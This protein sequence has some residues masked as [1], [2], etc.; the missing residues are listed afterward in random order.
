ML[1]TNFADNNAKNINISHI[2]FTI[3]CSYNLFVLFKEIVNFYSRSKLINQLASKL[4][5]LEKFIQKIFSIHN[6]FKISECQKHK[7]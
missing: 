6:N 2:L 1:I 7:A 4:N 3:H 5:N